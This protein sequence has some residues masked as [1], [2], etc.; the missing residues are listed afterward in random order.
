M[1]ESRI[2]WARMSRGLWFIGLGVFCLLST[3]G[4]LHRGFWFDAL[5]FWP[6]LL[7]TLGLRMVFERSRTPWVV[8]FSPLILVGILSYV[9]RRGPEPRPTDWTPVRA[10]RDAQVESWTLEARV[11]LADLDLRAG[12]LAP[13]VLLE[14]RTTT[15]AAGSV[16]V[17]DRGDSSR[18]T[19]GARRWRSG[20]YLVPATRQAWDMNV[21]NALPVALRLST[22]F[23]EGDID[24]RSIEVTR[25][26][27]EGAF[28]DL[29]L[30]L[31]EPR[32]D[33]RVNLEGAFNRLVLVVPER[34]P[35]RVST[36]GFLN[37]VDRRPDRGRLSGPA[38]RVRSTGAFNRVVIRSE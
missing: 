35:V 38:Y 12:S 26:D 28:N 6:V 2:V 25:V 22:A 14:G 13:G 11:A 3:Q 37:L 34:T 16:R 10:L 32:T 23:A 29:T 30:R 18:V 4:L 9:A 33:T 17:S 20:A 15:T 19:L 5:A 1:T 7:I 21:A 31:G 8:L 36:D 27:E 24:F